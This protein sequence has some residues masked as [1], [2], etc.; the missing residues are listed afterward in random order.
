[1]KSCEGGYDGRSQLR[2]TASDDADE[3]FAQLGRRPAVAERALDLRLEL[4]VLV[5]R[6]PSGSLIVYPPAEA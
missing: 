6:R 3:A 4:S 5:A 1:V 2:F